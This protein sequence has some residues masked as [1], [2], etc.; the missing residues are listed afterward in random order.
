MKS[1][2]VQYKILLIPIVGV[3]GFLSYLAVTF[4]NMNTTE[5]LLGSAKNVEFP[6][7]QAA[8]KSL[9]TL[10]KIKETLGSAVTTGEA[11]LLSNAQEL[12][13]L[14]RDELN[15]VKAL[16]G[17]NANKL[18][19]ILIAFDKYY[20]NAFELSKQL[21]DGSADF[22]KIGAK[23]E[24][25]NK[26]LA[27]LQALLN[28]F[29][30][31]RSTAFDTALNDV[32]SSSKQASNIGLIL[33][34]ITVGILFAVAIPIAN[35]I[36]S[37]LRDIIESMQNIAQ[38]NGDLTV[39][40]KTNSTDDFGDLVYWFNNFI[41]KLQGVISDV[42]QTAL[43]LADTASKISELS[44]QSMQTFD[45]Q[46]QS[47]EESQRSVEDMTS[48]VSSIT[49][50]AANAADAALNANTEAVRGK[51]V[52]ESTV[53][54]IRELAVNINE[55]ADTILKLEQD[56]NRVNVVLDVIK[57]IAEQ[58]NLLAL[59]AAIEA[60]RAGEQGRGFA[61]VADEVR[62]LA[63]RTQ[64]STEEINQML[65]QLQSAAQAA[66]S[67][68]EQ[69]KKKVD[70]SVE[71]ANIAGESLVVIN[72][73]VNTIADMNSAIA[74]ETEAQQ[75][76]SQLMVSHVDN[77]QS[78]TDEAVGASTEIAKVSEQLSDLA[79]DLETIARQFKV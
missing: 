2:S 13:N 36:R 17:N 74:S 45:N 67:T 39:R 33:A 11:E 8:D 64:E 20:D 27:A 15:Q 10:D 32:I 70:T 53:E 50:N 44:N 35:A 1:L 26:D 30:Q 3:I 43:P 4:S 41:E 18:S 7:L 14:F 49:A 19:A 73:T 23:S 24:T 54:D 51:E 9:V 34:V 55:S 79:S 56:T 59:N 21:V 68:M 47:V 72:D 40:L 5:Q 62:S 52:V 60:A 71:S 6:L 57:G 46:K 22:S 38:D 78:C 61:V 31:Q 37:N 58:T 76:T 25:M 28:A 75:N 48:S 29:Q 63:S 16:S 77:I 12:A 69:S 42:V 65:E 66:V